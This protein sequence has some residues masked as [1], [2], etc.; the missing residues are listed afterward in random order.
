VEEALSNLEVGFTSP[1]LKIEKTLS[2]LTVE[3]ISYTTLD[4]VYNHELQPEQIA[5]LNARY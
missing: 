1:I 2:S 4:D 3:Q 5:H